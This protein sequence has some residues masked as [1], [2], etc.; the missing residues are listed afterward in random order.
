MTLSTLY[1]ISQPVERIVRFNA[2][3]FHLLSLELEQYG[4]PFYGDKRMQSILR[5]YPRKKMSQLRQQRQKA[6]SETV[7]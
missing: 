2:S 1:L 5:T 7:L 3:K 6:S 4:L